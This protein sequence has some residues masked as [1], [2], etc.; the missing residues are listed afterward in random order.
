[1]ICLGDLAPCSDGGGQIAVG[2]VSY[3]GE[4]DIS[5]LLAEALTADVESV[6]ADQTGLVRA[7]AAA[8][9]LESVVSHLPSHCVRFPLPFRFASS[10]NGLRAAG[11][12]SSAYQA[13]EPLPYV[14]GREFQTVS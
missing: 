2:V 5:R 13:R 10:Q 7:D 14:F 11:S 1:M 8:I 4:A 9:V 12:E 3:L 6:L